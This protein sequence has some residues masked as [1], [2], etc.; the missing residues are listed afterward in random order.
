MNKRRFVAIVLSTLL[1]AGCGMSPAVTE[2]EMKDAASFALN[3][4]ASK[5]T[6]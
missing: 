4:D 6:I 2:K 3:V 1:L 5:V